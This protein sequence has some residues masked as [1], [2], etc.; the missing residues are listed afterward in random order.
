[1]R[2]ICKRA[3][4]SEA[5]LGAAR[6]AVAKSA[7]PSLEGILLR[8]EKNS[9][10][11]TGYDLEMGI[12]TEISAS[13][14]R[15]GQIVLGARLLCEILRR[16]DCDDVELTAGD[17][18]V[19]EIKGGNSHFSIV[20]TDSAD[21][22]E[23][24]VFSFESRASIPGKTL[25]GMIDQTL[26]AV[27]VN[28]QKPV[29]TGSLF[30]LSEDLLTV[31]SVDGFRQALCRE[32]IENHREQ[33][34]VV[35]GKTLGDLSKMISEDDDVVLDIGKRHIA[36]SFGSYRI[37]SR[38]LEGAFLDYKNTLPKESALSVRVGTR[39][40]QDAIERTSLLITDRLRS[41]LKVSFEDGLIKMNATTA[42]GKAYDEVRA[43]MR[44]D[45][46]RMG[47]NNRYLLDALRAAGCEEVRIEVSGP[48]SPIEILP[49]DGDS[50][51]FLV[52]PV[53][54]KTEE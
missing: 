30:E 50:F 48:L 28:D 54:L 10:F 37:F 17:D 42:M 2:F 19:V 32:K 35:P 7:I 47:F 16:M 3:T 9:V 33:S 24:P 25:K 6:A 34:F 18:L 20:G 29:H 41:P 14:G 38:L 49:P 23:I 40:L 27:S 36:F 44:G 5:A 12:T 52:L 43:V 26:F 15:E 11:L 1:M 53:R 51:L 8:A 31:V 4:L 22:P 21:Y 45:T 13:I 39:L 46:V